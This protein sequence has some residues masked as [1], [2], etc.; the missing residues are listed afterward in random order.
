[1][2]VTCKNVNCKHYYKLKEGQHCQAED[3]CAGYTANRKK[4]IKSRVKC[5]DCKYCKLVYTNGMKEYH[6]EC[7]AKDEARIILMIDSRICDCRS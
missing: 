1:M 7:R 3:A 5:K 6:Y 2:R 4:A